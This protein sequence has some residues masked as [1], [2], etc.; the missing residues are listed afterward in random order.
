MTN[1]IFLSFAAD[2]DVT[3]GGLPGLPDEAASVVTVLAY[4]VFGVLGLATGRIEARIGLAR[5]FCL[6]FIAAALSLMLIALVPTSWTA[7]ISSAGLQGVA[8]MMVSAVFSFW[9]VRSLPMR[10]TLGFAVRLLGMA[11]VSVLGPALAGLLAAAQGAPVVFLV[12]ATPPLAT[13]LWFGALL[14]RS[15]LRLSPPPKETS[16]GASEFGGHGTQFDWGIGIVCG[17]IGT[18]NQG[19]CPRTLCASPV[20]FRLRGR[21]HP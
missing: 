21:S 11:A 13:A 7:V 10:S 5:L 16:G 8:I 4:G 12:A 15:R 18:A 14:R 20:D 2:R 17:S 9:S 6:N 19:T 1:A 3:A